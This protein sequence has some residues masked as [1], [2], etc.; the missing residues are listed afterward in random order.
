MKFF[1]LLLT[2]I[3]SVCYAHI[4]NHAIS[5]ITL[6][7]PPY[8][9]YADRDEGEGRDEQVISLLHTQLST[10]DY[11]HHS[12]PASRAI[13]ELSHSPNG[14]CMISL[15][16]TASRK[17]YITY[18]KHH[19]TVGLSPGLALRKETILKLGLD[20]LKPVSLVDLM[21][22][23]DLTLGIAQSRSYGEK[24]DKLIERLPRDQIVIR[25][26]WDTLQSLTNMLVKKR[27]D[28]V[29]GYPSEH[30]YLSKRLGADN[31]TQ[32]S[33]I[34]VPLIAKGYIGCTNNAWGKKAVALFDQALVNL[35]KTEAYKRIMLKWLPTHLKDK[36]NR[37][38]IN[39]TARFNNEVHIG[40]DRN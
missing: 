4:E 18:T 17:K 1:L 12:F 23:H 33:L 37:H 21:L 14:Y 40:E 8:Y 27:V 2:C 35:V 39:E 28:L 36:L 31:L 32:I 3:T 30:Y 16:K 25:P 10:L 15:Y 26:G 38:L 29:L 7:F 11:Y 6:D 24:L 19:S 34:G 20:V 5:W 22:K 13:H 9:I